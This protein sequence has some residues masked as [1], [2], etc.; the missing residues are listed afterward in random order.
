MK[1]VVTGVSLCLIACVAG[2][3]QGDGTQAAVQ[4]E[5][6]KPAKVDV[7]T[8]RISQLRAPAGFTV[9]PFATG[10]KNPRML[11]VSADGT[12]YVTRREQGDVLMLRDSDGDGQADGAPVTVANRAGAHGIAIHGN[13]LYL[14]TVKEIF[15]ADLLPDGRLGPLEMITGDLPDGGQHPN[16]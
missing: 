1:T 4:A 15:R 7:T 11:A 8:E 10:L 9:L 2:A 12:V 13:Q 5:V 6:F 16:R 14:A 3:Q